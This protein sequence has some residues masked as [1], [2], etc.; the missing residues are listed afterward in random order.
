M[1]LKQNQDSRY[2][3]VDD[4][5]QKHKAQIAAFE[6]RDKAYGRA[7]LRRVYVSHELA[8]VD[9]TASW[10]SCKSIVLVESVRI[11]KKE[12]KSSLRYYISSLTEKKTETYAQ[13]VR[14]H[15]AIENGLH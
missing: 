15:W 13:Y 1:A 3:Q 12:Q 9:A 6:Q 11:D 8:F 4:Y 2:E 14:G 7:E 10:P 5:F